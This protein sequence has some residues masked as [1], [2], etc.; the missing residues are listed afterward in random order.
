VAVLDEVAPDA[1]VIDLEISV[2]RSAD[3]APGKAI[4]YRMSPGNLPAVTAAHP[5]ACALANNHVLDFGHTGLTDTLG[6]L[7]RVGL[8][9]VGCRAGPHPG[10]AARYHPA[11]GRPRRHLRL[12]GRLQR[13]PAPLGRG[14]WAAGRRSAAEPVRRCRQGPHRPDA[15]RQATR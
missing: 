2:T 11:A 15:G 7:A 10:P 8:P 6:A 4:C 12:R 9:A 1:R 14:R 5:D 13:N 3:F